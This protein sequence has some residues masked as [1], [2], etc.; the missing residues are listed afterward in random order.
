VRLVVAII[1]VAPA[2]AWD[3]GEPFGVVEARL[4]TAWTLR[5]DRGG[6]WQR[7][8]S[9]FEVE[10]T[11]G[12]AELGELALIDRG[13]AALAFDPA[14]PPPGYT[15]CH[16]GHCHA[17]GGRLVSYEEIS[18][19]LGG[20]GGPTPVLTLAVGAR[21]LVPGG[22]AALG[23]D[24]PCELPLATIGRVELAVARLELA[25]RVRD[26][27]QPPRLTGEV[28]WTLALDRTGDAAPVRGDVELPVDRG[29]DPRI[30][31]AAGFAPTAAL[32]DGVD[33]A[34]AG[35]GPWELDTDATARAA[36]E[37]A[38]TELPLAVTTDRHPF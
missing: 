35:A 9:D 36:V 8:A 27:R 16:N 32:L 12:R 28:A 23:C 5:A 17:D 4:A 34:Q 22:E 1:A 15:L 18:A 21:D 7:L 10:V 38:L 11:S 37:A 3:D 13:T 29:H 20:G 14:D 2:C 30:T 6:T 24:G 31:L 26:R 19:E 33:F 25:G